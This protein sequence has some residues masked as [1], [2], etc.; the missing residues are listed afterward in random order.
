VT[1]IV[2]LTPHS[3]TLRDVDG[4][5]HTFASA[6][7]ARVTSTPG[8]RELI[9]GVPVPVFGR[10]TFGEV[11][12]L[13]AP[14]DGVFYVVSGMVGAA[15]NGSRNDVLVPGTGPKDNAIRNEAGHIVAV[16]CLKRA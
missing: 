9:D 3:I 2:N 10:D 12:D 13:P 1:K 5:D 11:I 8:Q 14:A 7:V 16:T 6:G 4:A 15:L